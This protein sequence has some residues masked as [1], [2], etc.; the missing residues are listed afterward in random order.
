[1]DTR[2][3]LLK[4]ADR[5]V[6]TGGPNG[7]SFADLANEVGVR[8]ASIHYYFPTKTDLIREVVAER[9]A[10]LQQI[11]VD[12]ASKDPRDA[13][14]SYFAVYRRYGRTH[15]LCIIGAMVSELP[16]LPEE[17]KQDL[18]HLTTEI[19]IHL[20]SLLQR[21]RDEGVFFF[22]EDPEVRAFIIINSLMASVQMRRLQPHAFGARIEEALLSDLTRG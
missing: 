1:V 7:F 11:M 13:I 19:R 21:G 4:V 9:R 3:Q 17:L 15:T 22:D 18:Q 6:R 8:T 16:T 10:D 5:L 14:R 2:Q 20:T 12:T